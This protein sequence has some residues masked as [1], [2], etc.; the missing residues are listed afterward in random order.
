VVNG[1]ETTGIVATTKL[2]IHEL[3]GFL[4][5]W[6][7]NSSEP[8]LPRFNK[9]HHKPSM[10]EQLST[11]IYRLKVQQNKLEAA[12]SRMQQHDKDIFAKC[13]SAQM[14]HDTA[15]AS[16]Y[17]NECAELRKIA[18]VTLQSQL[19]LEQV[20]L[21]LE[22]IEEFGDVARMMGP[23]AGVIRTV[24]GQISGVLPEVGYE[25]SE[26]GEL[27]NSFVAEAGEPFG[28]SYEDTGASSEESQKILGEAGTIAEQHF[29]EK[30]PDI[31]T[32]ST[33]HLGE[34]GISH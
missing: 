31:P 27:L 21:R 2:E 4:R 22:T 8:I 28:S 13:V 15:R 3:N 19:A 18:K 34:S 23:V 29:K 20:S 6:E 7:E 25:L 32:G 30:F 1:H 33:Q 14:S 24:K 5:D 26:V 10:K 9:M 11:A 16:M 17:A 12:S